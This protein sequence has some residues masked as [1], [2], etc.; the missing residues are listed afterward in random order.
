MIRLQKA[1]Y[2]GREIDVVGRILGVRFEGGELLA[3]F[4]VNGTQDEAFLRAMTGR[5]DRIATMH[6]CGDSCPGVVTGECYLHGYEYEK[7]G[8]ANEDWFTNLD[9]VAEEAG[10]EIDENQKLREALAKA[11]EEGRD[12]GSSP[13]EKKEKKS[14]KDKGK[15][16]KKEKK[17]S[18]ASGSKKRK[19]ESSSVAEELVRGQK[20][21]E[22]LYEGAAL[23]PDVR[24]RG[25]LLKK[26]KRIGKKG[27]KKKKDSGGSEASSSSSSDTS[28][29]DDVTTGLFSP[30]RKIKAISEKC[31][32]AL[33]FTA[34]M[35]ARQNLLTT[36][37]MSW[38]MEKKVVAPIFMQYARQQMSQGM[39]PAMLQEAMTIS[40][41]ID[42]LMANR[43]AA[44][45]DVLCQRLKALE[46]LYRGS[47]WTVARQIELVRTEQL[48]L[49]QENEGLEAARRAKEDEKLKALM[50]ARPSGGRAPEGDGK[51]KGK[52]KQSKGPYKGRADE[53]GKGKNSDGKKDDKGP[54]Q[55][56]KDKWQWMCPLKLC[57]KVWTRSSV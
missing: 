50:H 57:M 48:G 37:G 45:A 40:T 56:K 32:G 49:I 20:T 13:K 53:A 9:V 22:A 23:D 29:D 1:V 3:E 27:K 24:S 5:K 41:S 34:L 38:G 55:G 44:A 4:K 42:L 43:P 14:K 10:D 2:Y 46:S 16:D 15:K 25:K 26:A 30:D 33:A 31:P 18:G 54:W 17:D 7:V 28:T 35:E 47:H 52:G 51:P 21:S 39:A 19:E 11:K 12:G 8:R 36:A 6:I